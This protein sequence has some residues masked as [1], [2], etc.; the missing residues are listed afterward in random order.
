MQLRETI[1]R[2]PYSIANFGDIP[3]GKKL[4]GRLVLATPRIAC[5]PIIPFPYTNDSQ[6]DSK[7]NMNFVLI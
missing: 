5:S 7:K 3:Y 6:K 2:I 4:T 1:D